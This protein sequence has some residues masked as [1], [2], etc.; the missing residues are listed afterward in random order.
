MS[1]EK[2]TIKQK[3]LFGEVISTE[4]PSLPQSSRRT[5]WLF[6]LLLIGCAVYAHFEG[7]GVALV[8]AA[9][10]LALLATILWFLARKTKPW[11]PGRNLL[12]LFTFFALPYAVFLALS[13]NIY[14]LPFYKPNQ[15]ATEF[16][17]LGTLLTAAVAFWSALENDGGHFK[18]NCAQLTLKELIKGSS[19]DFPPYGTLVIPKGVSQDSLVA[20]IAPG[21]SWFEDDHVIKIDVLPDEN[22]ALKGKNL[23]TKIELIPRDILRGVAV[24]IPTLDGTI[25][26]TIPPGTKASGR[27]RL[28][29]LGLPKGKGKK[30]GHLYVKIKVNEDE[31]WQPNKIDN[32]TWMVTLPALS[33][34]V[35]ED[36][37]A[38]VGYQISQRASKSTNL[39]IV[40]FRGRI[41]DDMT[42][43][44]RH[45]TNINRTARKLPN[46]QRKGPL[47]VALV[48]ERSGDI[49]CPFGDE[50]KRKI[51]SYLIS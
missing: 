29:G 22:F 9:E 8:V 34:S 50:L 14:Q 35:F 16:I 5:L 23:E 24:P 12:L 25:K 45:L 28:K 27:L 42:A 43:I 44:N 10:L 15:T 32:H 3:R 18:I 19:F 2:E 39:F 33:M 6:V 7:A 13:T 20:L 37:L 26:M 46:G 40:R 41:Q 38:N 36:L 1:A 48:D 51:E 30:R 4:A 31:D 17:A 21:G 11:R 49:I 47:L